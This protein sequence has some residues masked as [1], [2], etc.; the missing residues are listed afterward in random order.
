MLYSCTHVTTV[1]IKGLVSIG[2]FRGGHTWHV[3]AVGSES[4]TCIL[5]K[6]ENCGTN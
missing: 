1:G 5:F 4:Q 2:R 3:A 6:R